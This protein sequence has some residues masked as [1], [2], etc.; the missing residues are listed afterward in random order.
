MKKIL[1]FSVL[2][3]LLLVGCKPTEKNYRAAYDAAIGKRQAEQKALD[4]DGLIAE[5]APRPMYMD[6]DT[7]YFAN[8]V[9]K[10]DDRLKALNVAV[11]MFKMNT[12]AISGAKALQDKGIDAFPVQAFGDKW[13]I[14]GGAFANLDEARAFMKEFRAKN[15][16]Y[17]H[18]GLGGHP[19]IIRR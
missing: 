4:A 14:I 16:D 3:A 8:D 18:I 1:F 19:V 2:V 6:G 7:I 15:P 10:A 13:Y 17:P 9:L 5:D 12:N 11:A